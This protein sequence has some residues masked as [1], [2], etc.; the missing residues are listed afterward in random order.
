MEYHQLI[1]S[2][3]FY[4]EA[5]VVFDYEKAQ[6]DELDLKVGQVIQDVVEVC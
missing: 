2:V 4:A 6:D 1:V 3:L 5:V